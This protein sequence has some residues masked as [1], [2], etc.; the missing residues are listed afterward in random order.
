MQY[1]EVVDSMGDDVLEEM[2]QKIVIYVMTLILP[3]GGSMKYIATLNI[4]LIHL[5]KRMYINYT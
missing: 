4:Y 5:N 3:V 1:E 2:E